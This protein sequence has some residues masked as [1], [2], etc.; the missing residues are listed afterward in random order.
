MDELHILGNVTLFCV[1]LEE[2]T[3]THTKRKLGLAIGIPHKPSTY[4][5]KKAQNNG[6]NT[7]YLCGLRSIRFSKKLHIYTLLS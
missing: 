5:I 1:H 3:K 2:I 4:K 6:L 7:F